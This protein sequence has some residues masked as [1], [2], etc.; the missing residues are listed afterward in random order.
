[1]KYTPRPAFIKNMADKFMEDFE[2]KKSTYIAIHWNFEKDYE[3][4][5][6]KDQNQG[7]LRFRKVIWVKFN[8]KAS[9]AI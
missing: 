7:Q 4:A 1:M 5:C 2:L 6:K 8:L 3:D 9:F